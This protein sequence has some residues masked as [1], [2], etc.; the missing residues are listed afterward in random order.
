MAAYVFISNVEIKDK[1]C[2]LAN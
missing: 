2:K 1:N